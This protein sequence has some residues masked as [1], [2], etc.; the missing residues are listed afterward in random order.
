[1]PGG[2]SRVV[3]ERCSALKALPLHAVIAAFAV[4]SRGVCSRAVVTVTGSPPGIQKPMLTLVSVALP[5]RVGGNNQRRA[6]TLPSS[7]ASSARVCQS[8]PTN[9]GW[10][11]SLQY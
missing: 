8:T 9:N 5:G 1:M 11:C 10:L 6:R 3:V 2:R 7:P 4:R